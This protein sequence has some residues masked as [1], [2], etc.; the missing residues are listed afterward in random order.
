MRS[1]KLY[2]TCQLTGWSLYAALGVLML[3]VFAERSWASVL[4]PLVVCTIAL[5]LSHGYRRLIRRRRWTELSPTAQLPRIVL[6]SLVLSALLNSIATLLLLFVFRAFTF[7]EFRGSYLLVYIFQWSTIYLVWSLL[8]FGF[9]HVESRRRAEVERWQ[10][11]AA[12][13]DAEL[14]TLKAQVNP[15]FL[16]NSLNSLRAM[17]REDPARAEEMVTQLAALLRHALKATG[18]QT[19][20]FGEEMRVVEDYLALEKTRLEDRLHV[21]V[22]VDPASLAVRVPTMLVQTLVENSVKHGIAPRTGGGRLTLKSCVLDSVLHI[23]ITNPGTI[24]SDPHDDALGLRNAAERLRLLFGE[25]AT[26]GLEQTE[27]VT[28]NPTTLVTARVRIPAGTCEA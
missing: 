3:Y 26:L 6:A 10:L 1:S 24:S 19:V 2:W 11:V 28:S 16:F 23:E 15:H 9:Q 25:R 18:T 22:E 4:Q 13:K 20:T 7:R 14:N 21:S 8:Y 27:A 17:I 5:L 12:I